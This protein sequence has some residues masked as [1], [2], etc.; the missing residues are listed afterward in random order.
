MREI[1]TGAFDDDA[2]GRVV[3]PRCEPRLRQIVTNQHPPR[4]VGE[5]GLRPRRD[6]CIQHVVADRAAAR[7]YDDF[8][9]ARRSGPA[10]R[11]R[12]LDDVSGV[13]R[14]VGN[15]AHPGKCCV[16]RDQG[17]VAVDQHDIEIF[18]HPR[19]HFI[20]ALGLV[21]FDEDIPDRRGD[22]GPVRVGARAL[23]H[24]LDLKTHLAAPERVHLD[25]Y[26]IGSG[27]VVD[28]QQSIPA[29]CL[30][31]IVDLTVVFVDQ[32]FE[33]DISGA[34]WRQLNE[35]AGARIEARDGCAAGNER[36]PRT[37]P[38][39]GRGSALRRA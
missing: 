13:A 10:F 27:V 20:D 35:A 14:L 26:D 5:S 1:R 19:N 2:V 6:R 36:P 23:E 17:G 7:R 9:V 3:A 22:D 12:R 29:I 39:E 18:V 25:Q 11:R 33:K 21:R 24:R 38:P 31:G 16:E 4:Q 30:P 32:Y 37:L 8:A 34:G 28:R 15:L